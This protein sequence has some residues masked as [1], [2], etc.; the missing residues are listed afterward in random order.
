M[1]PWRREYRRAEKTCREAVPGTVG[2]VTAT[3]EALRIAA[4]GAAETGD[5]DA[6]PL[7][8]ALSKRVLVA[9]TLAATWRTLAG[10]LPPPDVRSVRVDEASVLRL[11][12]DARREH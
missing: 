6:L 3:V 10:D 9:S 5:V 4:I 7:V 11:V 2:C 8:E 12:R 1:K